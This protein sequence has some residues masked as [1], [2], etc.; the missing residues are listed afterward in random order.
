MHKRVLKFKM[1]RIYTISRL[2]AVMINKYTALIMCIFAFIGFSASANASNL[3]SSGIS[4]NNIQAEDTV[5]LKVN[6][7]R[8]LRRR[9]RNLRRQLRNAPVAGRG[10]IRIR[11][12][13]LNRRI[14]RMVRNNTPR[15]NSVPEI[16][17]Y[18]GGAALVVFLFG[19]L[20]IRERFNRG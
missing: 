6:T 9:V 14:R 8:V 1:S 16:N 17:V 2:G 5:I 3:I 4:A 10:A 12:R 13:R 11:I 15:P 20:L 18:S 7:P 19:M